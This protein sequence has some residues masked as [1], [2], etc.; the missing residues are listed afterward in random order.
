MK[1]TVRE[2]AELL[3]VGKT[4]AA[5]AVNE[6]KKMNKDDTFEENLNEAREFLKS[7]GFISTYENEVIFNKNSKLY[8]QVQENKSKSRG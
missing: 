6:I 4:T 8:L 3:Y 7:N 1:Y 2:I 5:K